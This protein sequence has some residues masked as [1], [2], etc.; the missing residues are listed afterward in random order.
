MKKWLCL[1][2]TL[3]LCLSAACG[4]LADCTLTEIGT[5]EDADWV[6][7]SSLLRVRTKDGYRVC[8]IAGNALTQ[9]AYNSS[10]TYKF[11][12]VTGS[13]VEGGLNS[14]GLFDTT[15]KVIMPYQYG[16][17]EILSRDWALGVKLVEATADNYDYTAWGSEDAYFLID[18]VDVYNLTKGTLA[19]TFARANFKDADVAGNVINIEDRSNGVITSYDA[20]MNALGTVKYTWDETYA[21]MELTTFRENGQ[22]GLKDAAGNVVMA[23]SFYTIYDF[24]G[25]YATVST[26]EK[27]GLIDRQGNVVIPAEYDEIKRGYYG[28]YDPV[29]DT[30]SFNAAGYFA[31]V[32]DGKL[33]FVDGQ[34]NVTCEPKYSE[35]VMELYGAS[36]TYSDMEGVT[37]ILAADGSDVAVEGYEKVYCMDGSAGMLYRVNDADYNYGVIDWHGNVVFECAYND[38]ELSGDGRYMLVNKDYDTPYTLYEVGY[39]AAQSAAPAAPAAPEAPAAPDAPA[40]PEAPA[41][42]DAPQGAANARSAIAGALGRDNGEAPAAQ[43]EAA[44]QSGLT[45]AKVIVS[46]V[47]TLLEADAEANKASVTMM[48]DDVITL[49]QDA[50]VQAIITS[51]KTLIETDAAA[52]AAT[53]V[54]LLHSIETLL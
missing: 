21:T 39:P 28:P 16:D 2:L 37:H 12:Y 4:A 29:T 46:T 1:L 24:Y 20:D 34:G 25:D 22:Y 52:N 9:D 49:N 19:G 35:K 15:G 45:D 33:G 6:S 51:V 41:A 47:I 44:T 8:D 5:I 48:L 23:P 36:A 50:S 3:A 7:D 30:D 42:P 27:E 43:T 18:T 54:T 40:A 32:K 26:G 31:V 13:I 14:T 10:L 11:G 17:I 38:I 53:A